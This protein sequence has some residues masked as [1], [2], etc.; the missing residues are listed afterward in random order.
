MDPLS[1][2][3]LQAL[4]AGDLDATQLA[5]RLDADA[6][7]SLAAYHDI[8]AALETP[9][10]PFASGFADRVSASIAARDAAPDAARPASLWWALAVAA[11]A[12]VPA[13]A[14]LRSP[15]LAAA[16]GRWLPAS[17]AV[18][19]GAAPYAVLALVLLTLTEALDRVVRR[20]G[21]Y[22]S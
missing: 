6:Q 18:V 3:D 1:D 10:E 22:P 14:A 13:L 16:L 20:R 4:L 12:S 17:E 19:A 11:L 8:W 2:H 15:A 7:A 21:A 5:G 9:S